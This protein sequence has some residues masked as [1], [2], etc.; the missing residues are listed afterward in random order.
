M[1]RQARH[2]LIGCRTGQS[3]GNCLASNGRCNSLIKHALH[4]P[5]PINRMML[6]LESR[7]LP[8]TFFIRQCSQRSKE[9]L[10]ANHLLSE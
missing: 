6:S 2:P 10:L 5:C 7:F 8:K 1:G 4:R 9:L 3:T